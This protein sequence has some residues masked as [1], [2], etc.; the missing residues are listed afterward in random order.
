[1]FSTPIGVKREDFRQATRRAKKY[2]AHT[3]E[4]LRLADSATV[5]EVRDYHREVAWHYLQLAEKEKPF[6]VSERK[7]PPVGNALRATAE[8]RPG[9]PL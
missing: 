6:S 5:Q 8:R 9:S 1:M 4:N 3:A 2:H 7:G